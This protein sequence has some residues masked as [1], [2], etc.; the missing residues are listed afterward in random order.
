M[1]F[2]GVGEGFSRG[3]KVLGVVEGGKGGVG[4]YFSVWEVMG[5][6]LFGVFLKVLL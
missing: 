1:C 2:G 4:F 6:L 3:L 5:N